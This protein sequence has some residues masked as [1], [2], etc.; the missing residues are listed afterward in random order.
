[1][2]REIMAE[3]KGED[4]RRVRWT[5]FAGKVLMYPLVLLIWPLVIVIIIQELYFLSRD[6]W[7]PDPEA[8]YN[9]QRKHLV[10]VV[11][12][13]AAEGSAKVVDPLGRTPDLPFGHLNS[14][15]CALLAD[16][17]VGDTLWYFEIPGYTPEPDNSPHLHQWSEPRGAKRGYALVQSGKV[18][19]E[20]IFE[21]D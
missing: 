14:G 1:M 17:Q 11:S 20:F 12:P 16:K 8:D 15:W 10:R 2:L 21:W 9:C 6:Q 7:T 4:S 3:L 13:E 18:R 5:R 19:N